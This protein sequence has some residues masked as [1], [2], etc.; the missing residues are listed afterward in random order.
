MRKRCL[1][2]FS[3]VIEMIRLSVNVLSSA[4][5]LLHQL[6]IYYFA[7]LTELTY[8]KIASISVEDIFEFSRN[9]GWVCES[10][11]IP[12]LTT[13]GKEFLK[14]YDQGLQSDLNRA[15][16]TDYVINASPLWS[17]RIPYGRSEA[18]IFMTKDEKACFTEAGLLSDQLD[19]GIVEWWDSIAGRIRAKA[20]QS[21]NHTGRI[22]ESNTIKY[23]RA[24]T[25]SEPKW[26]SIDSNLAG[27]DVKSKLSADDHRAL[28]IEVKTSTCSLDQAYFYVT[29]HEWSVA[30][31]SPAYVFHLWCLSGNK[32]LL[33]VI[34]PDDIYPYIPTNN[35][36]GKW[37]S[38]EIPFIC[39][40]SYFVEVA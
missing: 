21:Q 6:E 39:F 36:A 7:S 13:R 12:A 40:E 17:N 37:E 8:M 14:L 19:S 10:G 9:C 32:K 24:R 22:G 18:A 38:A 25:N 31:T 20:Q 28:L 23:E 5:L 15:M 11:N 29:S 34:S 35:L 26:M 2:I 27:Y 33:A 4:I 30:Q 16:L 1:I 3:V